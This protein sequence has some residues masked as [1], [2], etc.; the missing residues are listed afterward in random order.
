MYKVLTTML[1]YGL[2]SFLIT[3]LW[4]PATADAADATDD[5]IWQ[6][7]NGQVHY[8]RMIEGIR[9]GGYDIR[10]LGN[11]SKRIVGV[12]DVDGDGWEDILWFNNKRVLSYWKMQ[13]DQFI[14]NIVI[15][16]SFV[17][18]HK[19]AL[20]GFGDIVGDEYSEII[21]R[22]KKKNWLRY[23]EFRGKTLIRTTFISGKKNFSR[24]RLAAV[25]DLDGDGFEDLVWQHREN[26][27]ISYWKMVNGQRNAVY[28]IEVDADGWLVKGGGDVDGDGD[29]DLIWQNPESGQVSYSQ[30]G[31]SRQENRIVVEVDWLIDLPVE[32]GWQLKGVG[33]LR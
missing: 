21:W 29:G 23:T 4:F 16:T 8:W 19:W 33:D 13:G 6:H 12:G 3:P 15:G 27:D 24:F 10:R 22:H 25:T 17:P 32:S 18:G 9:E 14:E 2:T 30:M 1:L 31:Y 20:A 7:D 5:I 26:G 28:D 11:M